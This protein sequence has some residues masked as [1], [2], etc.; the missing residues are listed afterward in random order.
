MTGRDH[1][2]RSKAT[3][4]RTARVP[5]RRRRAATGPASIEEEEPSAKITCNRVDERR[6]DRLCKC[7]DP[8]DHVEEARGWWNSDASVRS[9]RVGKG[10]DR[11]LMELGSSWSEGSD[12][13]ATTKGFS[14]SFTTEEAKERQ[15]G[16]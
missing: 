7:A 13:V 8:S 5:R 3:R 10:H 11:R 15:G 16:K 9:Y 1:S 2:R 4:L 14:I 12:E 6:L